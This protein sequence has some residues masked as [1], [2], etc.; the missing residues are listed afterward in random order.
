MR[1]VEQFCGG[2]GQ[3]ID[4]ADA[5]EMVAE[6]AALQAPSPTSSA[7]PGVE[8]EHE[9][10]WGLERFTFS[11]ILGEGGTGTVYLA[12]DAVTGADVAVKLLDRQLSDS[13]GYLERFFAEVE[14]LSGLPHSNVVRIVDHGRE[15]TQAW[16]ATEYVPGGSL[17]QLLD[18]DGRLSPAQALGVLS[19]VLAGLV[20]VH[21]AGV[22]HGDLTPGNILM[23][24][25]G[26]SKLTDFGSAIGPSG[27]GFGVTAAYASPEA[28]QGLPLDERS[29]VYSMGVVLYEC[30][31]GHRPFQGSSDEVVLHRHLTVDPPPIEDLARPLRE[32]VAVALGQ[33]PRATSAERGRTP[34]SPR[35]GGRPG[36]G[37]NLA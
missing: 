6:E 12:H 19:G 32:L 3:R 17:R 9:A 28:A 15:G 14:T 16:L 35:G 1:G 33:G 2:C 8:P 5:V 25:T 27:R 20:Y 24:P 30:L 22:L 18:H 36:R 4:N 11:G 7:V 31:A 23:D 21:E 37:S 29:D 34:G 26:T 13:P 10:A